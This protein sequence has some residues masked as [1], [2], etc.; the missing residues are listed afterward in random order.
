MGLL[1]RERKKYKVEGERVYIA[2][3]KRM[4][5]TKSPRSHVLELRC[6]P[7]QDFG[8]HNDGHH[9]STDVGIRDGSI[10]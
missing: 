5:I 9:R 10:Y 3:N 7:I 1:S 2:K 8:N 4:D 6:W